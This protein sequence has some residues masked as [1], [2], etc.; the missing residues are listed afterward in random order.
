MSQ[1]KKAPQSCSDDESSDE[2]AEWNWD[3]AEQHKEYI[4]KCD[5][6]LI[7]TFVSNLIHSF[8]L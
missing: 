2:E 6:D 3:H 7:V 1:T 5:I 4:A 8:L